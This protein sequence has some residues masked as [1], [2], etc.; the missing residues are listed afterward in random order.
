MLTC[1][2][3][4]RMF[5]GELR[6]VSYWEV[7]K[8]GHSHKG[9]LGLGISEGLWTWVTSRYGVEGYANG[10]KERVYEGI[11]NSGVSESSSLAADTESS[12]SLWADSAECCR[13]SSERSLRDLRGDLK[14]LIG[15]ESSDESLC[16]P[17]DV[18]LVTE[19]AGMPSLLDEPTREN[20]S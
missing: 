12:S 11:S 10:L 20:P 9:G 1:A 2:Y 17:F 13:L 5:L 19:E 16:P 18:G 8:Y 6:D 4:S 14:V 15:G 7:I 3:F